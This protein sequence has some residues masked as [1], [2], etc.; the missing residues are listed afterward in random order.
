MSEVSIQ[1]LKL[2]AA[3]VRGPN[4]VDG[5]EDDD[6]PDAAAEIAAST[7]IED[8]IPVNSK[9]K[10]KKRHTK[11]SDNRMRFYAIFITFLTSMSIFGRR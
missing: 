9:S 3:K 7:D 6:I 11:A 5:D 10:A 4:T 2:I 8:S 1:K